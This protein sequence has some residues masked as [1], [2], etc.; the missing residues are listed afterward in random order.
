MENDLKKQRAQEVKHESLSALGLNSSGYSGGMA[1]VSA[2]EV[3]VNLFSL[4]ENGQI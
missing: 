3:Q 2:E 1:T 4:F